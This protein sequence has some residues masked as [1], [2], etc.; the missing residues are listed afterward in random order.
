MNINNV[1]NNY[2]TLNIF[3]IIFILFTYIEHFNKCRVLSKC[4]SYT[5][6]SL[7]FS[8]VY[9]VWYT[10]PAVEQGL[11]LA[12]LP[13][14]LLMIWACI[15]AELAQHVPKSKCLGLHST[16]VSHPRFRWGQQR[17]HFVAF[18]A[19]YVSDCLCIL[20][21]RSTFLIYH[22][23]Y[24]NLTTWNVSCFDVSILLNTYYIFCD[25][26]STSTCNERNLY[27]ILWM[28]ITK[29]KWEKL[30]I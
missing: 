22:L 3:P 18:S 21:N 10:L 6:L 28:L 5:L 16:L 11:N 19:D 14:L 12:S 7:L 17:S 29:I 24:I 1:Y 27:V 15:F 20:T 8:Y 26:I 9:Y 13:L 30:L 25:E 4:T 23:S 2:N